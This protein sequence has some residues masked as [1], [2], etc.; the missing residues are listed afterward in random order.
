MWKNQHGWKLGPVTPPTAD[1]R[2]AGVASAGGTH[3]L[4]RNVGRCEPLRRIV[5]LLTMARS[6]WDVPPSQQQFS[7]VSP[8]I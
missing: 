3:R 2:Q 7:S 5:Q 8:Y 1:R 4:H 6:V